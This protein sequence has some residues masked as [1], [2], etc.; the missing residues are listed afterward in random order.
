L[1]R[2]LADA[3]AADR[4]RPGAPCGPRGPRSWRPDCARRC[5]RGIGR[6]VPVGTGTGPFP[7]VCAATDGVSAAFQLDACDPR[8]GG[9]RS[10]QHAVPRTSGAKTVR[11]DG[12][13]GAFPAIDPMPVSSG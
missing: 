9:N 5:M 1:P 3:P 12:R 6:I 10:R 13:A 7:D 2:R 4:P 8:P 11:W